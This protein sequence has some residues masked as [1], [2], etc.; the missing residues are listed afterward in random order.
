MT[1]TTLPYTADA[2]TQIGALLGGEPTREPYTVR[3]AAVYRLDVFNP[4]LSTH[5]SLIL[6]PSLA[7]VDVHLGDCSIVYRDVATVELLHGVEVIFRR[8]AAPGYLFVSIGGRA[9]VVV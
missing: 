8:A 1:L 6:W 5:I 7:R 3:G 2:I 9:S 4:V